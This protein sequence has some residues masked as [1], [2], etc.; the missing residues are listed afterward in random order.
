MDKETRDQHRQHVIDLVGQTLGLSG[1]DAAKV[2]N[3]ASRHFDPPKP[4]AYTPADHSEFDA[5]VFAVVQQYG[6]ADSKLAAAA[7]DGVKPAS[8]KHALKRLARD[9]KLRQLTDTL[10][11]TV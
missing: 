10:F 1:K 11:T 9:G 2:C 8:C 3:A 6:T 5:Q 4:Q 7:L